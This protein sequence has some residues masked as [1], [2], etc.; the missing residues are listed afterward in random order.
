MEVPRTQS[1]EMEIMRAEKK[2]KLDRS[3]SP[4]IC[5]TGIPK[6]ENSK[7]GEEIT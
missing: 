6:E 3:R 4:N 5:S 7:E 2:D 1:S